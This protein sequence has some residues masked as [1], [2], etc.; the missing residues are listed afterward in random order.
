MG[1]SGFSCTFDPLLQRD[2]G[3]TAGA[4]AVPI[5]ERRLTKGCQA[6]LAATSRPWRVMLLQGSKARSAP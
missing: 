4:A 3:G 5:S 1:A 2:A 6:R